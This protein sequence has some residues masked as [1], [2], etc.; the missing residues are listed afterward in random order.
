MK[1]LSEKIN[2]AR[3]IVIKIGSNILVEENALKA[4]WMESLAQ[5]IAEL[6]N[7]GKEILVVSSGAIA[8]GMREFRR[9]QDELELK[10]KQAA[11]AIGQIDLAHA[12]RKILDAQNL[13]CAQVLLTL[14]DGEN[15]RRFLN[16]RNTLGVLLE[17]AIVPII[18]E[19][20]TVA[21]EEIRFGD[22]DRLAANVAQM[23]GADL[24]ILLSDVAG[25]YDK[26]PNKNADA[27]LISVVEKIDENVEQ[28]ASSEKSSYGTGGMIAKIEAAKIATENNA[29]MIIGDGRVQNPIKNLCK[30]NI[31]TI[32]LKEE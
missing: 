26:N 4:A 11:A 18:N 21:T 32:F 25:L 22:N 3:R 28:M 1:S 31:G 20:D 14:D 7:D 29:D 23:V 24:V 27:K 30:E 19:N 8:L 10:E 17:R 9:A 16:A 15:K 2:S 12:W 5:D 6:K 13:E